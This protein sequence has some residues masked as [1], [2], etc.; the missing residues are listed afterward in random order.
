LYYM[1][2]YCKTFFFIVVLSFT[3]LTI[4]QSFAENVTTSVPPNAISTSNGSWV[5]PL[6][7]TNSS[8]GKL[9]IHVE[10]G[11]DVSGKIMPP[12]PTEN[13]ETPKQFQT[14]LQQFKSGIA[15]KDVV[16]INGLTLVIKA[17]DGSPACVTPNT[18]NILIERGWGHQP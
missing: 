1:I 6:Q 13:M 9:N 2:N 12:P 10:K 4:H 16:C 5:T 15:A 17:E 8:G 14:P 11:V 18:A 7:T 3:M